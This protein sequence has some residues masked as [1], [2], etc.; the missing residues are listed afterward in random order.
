MIPISSK[1]AGATPA[2]R[3]PRGTIMLIAIA[4]VLILTSLLLVFVREMRVE[5]Q[6]CSNRV[7][8]LQ[9][10]AIARGGIA[11]AVNN[12]TSNQDPI[13]LD[14]QM[15][16]EAQPLG[17]GYFWL[18]RPNA[19]DETQYDF[20]LIDEAS[21]LN[22]NTA[23]Y[24]MLM[25]LPNMSTDLAA[26]IIDWRDADDDVTPNGGA[27]NEYYLLLPEPYYCK[28]GAFETIEEVM[29][30]HGASRDVL[31]ATDANR[32][33]V[34]D[35]A[36]DTGAASQGLSGINGNARCG[37]MKY[38]TCYSSEANTDANGKPRTN[39][40]TASNQQIE[41]LFGKSM[42]TQRIK[43]ITDTITALRRN[44][45]GPILFKSIFDFYY[46]LA[47][48]PLEFAKVADKITINPAKTIQGL[49]NVNTAP[50]EVLACLPGLQEGDAA[51]LFDRR[52]ANGTD[53]STLAWILDVL[54]PA[55]SIPIANFITS[56]TRRFSAD[57]VAVGSGG[58]GF[59]RIRCVFSVNGT[60][61]AMLYS[62]DLSHLG[63]P[64][65]PAIL[66][67][68]RAGRGLGNTATQTPFGNTGS[69]SQGSSSGFG[70]LH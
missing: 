22:I 28:N 29:L 10:S 1:R 8:S 35:A 20:G 43:Q 50:K 27:E 40:N 60:T 68:L 23:T 42:T 38:M 51:A 4:V 9:A 57:I 69:G 48:T 56:R 55:K 13:S 7:Q 31:Y 36:E 61:P 3:Q 25:A 16:S 21:K 41:Q 59:K 63:W 67:N 12:L 24:D 34:V 47:L 30:V 52:N 15:I 70:G 44:N 11:Y 14:T 58:L 17:D 18:L 62:K 26:S 66:E 46:K 65:D 37:V 33:G 19:A 64:L 45:R 5:A 2:P 39:I 32:N 53:L 54:P 49:I 6:A